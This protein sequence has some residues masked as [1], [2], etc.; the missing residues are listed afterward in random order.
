MVYDLLSSYIMSALF[1]VIFIFQLMRY[2]LLDSQKCSYDHKRWFFY[3]GLA[4][5]S[6]MT[7]WHDFQYYKEAG[8]Y[9]LTDYNGFSSFLF[10]HGLLVMILGHIL[11]LA[12]MFLF[13]YLIFG[14]LTEKGIHLDRFIAFKNMIGYQVDS[15]FN[16]IDIEYRTVFSKIRRR[17]IK[18]DEE[19]IRK[20]K[21]HL[22]KH[23][24]YL[25]EV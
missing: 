12:I 15:D 21:E 24:I 13:D 11:L 22:D 9:K 18:S 14:R 4:L 25:K 7:K 16:W 6:F 23:H 8:I 1:L 17:I 5:F 2:H 10:D 19:E 20:I 3:I